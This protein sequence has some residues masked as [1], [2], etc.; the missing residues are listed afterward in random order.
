MDEAPNTIPSKVPVMIGAAVN[1]GMLASS[2][3]YGRN[4]ASGAGPLAGVL[5]SGWRVRRGFWAMG[6]SL[7]TRP[8]DCK[9]RHG[10]RR[11]GPRERPRSPWDRPTGRLAGSSPAAPAGLQDYEH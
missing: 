11:A 5:M 1:S 4:S 7:A 9:G 2:G 6:P 10:K 8:G 3:T